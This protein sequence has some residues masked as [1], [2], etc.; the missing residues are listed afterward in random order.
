M[1]L[2]DFLKLSPEAASELLPSMTPPQA[3]AWMKS[4]QNATG[5]DLGNLVDRRE[6]SRD[7]FLK[8]I[9]PIFTT[10]TIAGQSIIRSMGMIS[11][12]IVFGGN[13]LRGVIGEIQEI[14]GGQNS[15]FSDIVEQHNEIVANKI[16]EMA[17][18][19]GCNAVVSFRREV[20]V[21]GARGNSVLVSV[22]G[23]AVIIESDSMTRSLPDNSV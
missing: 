19:I 18:K 14:T 22:Y 16:F 3:S 9:L 20:S 17:E 21:F 6:V 10:E 1:T 4:Y 13:A 12:T 23:T 2:A 11:A 5:V 7:V 8:K 15:G